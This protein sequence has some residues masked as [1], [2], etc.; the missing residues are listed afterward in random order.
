MLAILS[1]SSNRDAIDNEIFGWLIY[2]QL[3]S[4]VLIPCARFLFSNPVVLL[5]CRTLLFLPFCF[6]GSF[7]SDGRNFFDVKTVVGGNGILFSPSFIAHRYPIKIDDCSVNDRK[8]VELISKIVCIIVV[9]LWLCWQQFINA[10]APLW[11]FGV[12]AYDLI[13]AVFTT[14]FKTAAFC[15]RITL[16]IRSL[17]TSRFPACLLVWWRCWVCMLVVAACRTYTME[18]HI[19]LSINIHIPHPQI[20]CGPIFI[21]CINHLTCT[22]YRSMKCGSICFCNT[23][24]CCTDTN[25]Y[26]SLHWQ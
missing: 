9:K 11:L 18:R 24:M 26:Y 4:S 5:S 22:I 3:C 1:E 8:L 2:I 10:T 25:M 12:G 20:S 16:E 19:I 21:I 15:L 23:H 13:T 14:A 7:S 17:Q 6:A